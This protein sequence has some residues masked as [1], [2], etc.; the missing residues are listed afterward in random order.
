VRRADAPTTPTRP[1]V[2]PATALRALLAIVL[3]W[4]GGTGLAHH[5]AWARTWRTAQLDTTAS[6]LS[7]AIPLAA[8]AAAALLA[9]R[10]GAFT[11]AVVATAPACIAVVTTV[12]T[13]LHGAPVACTCIGTAVRHGTRANVEAIVGDVALLALACVTAWWTRDTRTLA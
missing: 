7:I 12:V 4:V 5:T 9:S 1:R 2:G 10:R 13:W 6:V 11:G 3:L 8:L